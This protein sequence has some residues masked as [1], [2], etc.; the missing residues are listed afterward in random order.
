MSG[1]KRWFMM[2]NQREQMLVSVAGAILFFSV[3]WLAILKP[4]LNKNKALKSGIETRQ[5]ELQ[6]MQSNGHTLKQLR[7]TH[8]G[9]GT[10]KAPANPSRLIEQALN[11]YGLK[12]SLQRMQ[13]RETVNLSLKAVNADQ[14][15]TLLGILENRHHLYVQRIE[16]TPK[17]KPGIIDVSMMI[18][19]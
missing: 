10:G 17:K 9:Q 1:I 19:K 14:V 2:L 11:Q 6:W 4:T 7:A 15:M 16:I 12:K 5:N 3:L 8:Q 13:G 18:G